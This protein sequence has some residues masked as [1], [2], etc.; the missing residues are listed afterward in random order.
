MELT[1]CLRMFLDM[2]YQLIQLA[3]QKLLV[4]SPVSAWRT[5]LSTD[6]EECMITED[7]ILLCTLIFGIT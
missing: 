1:A 5:F 4:L 3:S 2:V 6:K 7:D